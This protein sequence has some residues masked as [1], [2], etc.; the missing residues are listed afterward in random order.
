MKIRIG[1]TIIIK[2]DIKTNGQDISLS[3]RDLRIFLSCPFETKELKNFVIEENRIEIKIEGFQQK[4]VGRYDLT[5]YENYGKANQSVVDA[6]NAF[7]LVERS[8]QA[9]QDSSDAIAVEYVELTGNVQTLIGTL[10]RVMSIT[11][12]PCGSDE[13]Y[14]VG[15]VS[16]ELFEQFFD[17]L[18]EPK[19]EEP[20]YPIYP[21]YAYGDMGDGE[22]FSG[23]GE[24][25]EAE[26]ASDGEV[27][28]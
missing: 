22:N 13:K 3:D 14:A 27:G 21:Y 7:T 15:Q 11:F 24:W 4:N 6:C 1:Q 9:S 17:E 5:L 28:A 18:P 2:W 10:P 20:S 16:G 26:D 12:S 8:C 19:P 23:I 25:D